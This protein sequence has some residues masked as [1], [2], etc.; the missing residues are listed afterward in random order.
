MS[1]RARFV[2]YLAAVHVLMAILAWQVVAMNRLWLIAAELVL[3]GSF[4]LGL[5]LVRGFFA[6]L[7]FVHDSAQLLEDSDL[8]SRVRDVGQPEIDRLI[9]VYNRMVDSLREERVRLQEQHHFLT[10]VLHESP[11]GIL[12]LDLEG[13]ITLM[14]PAAERLL[15]LPGGRATET[16]PAALDHPLA[17]E[18]ARVPAGESRVVALWGGRRVRIVHGTFPDRGFRRS[19]YLLE[20]LTEELR[21]S[22]KAAYER[23]IRM[24]SHEVNNTVGAS[25]SL[26]HSCLEYGEQLRP[27]DRRDY[28]NALRVVIA[29]TEQLTLFMRSFADVVRLPPPQRRP[30]DIRELLDGI[31]GLLE[32]E[33]ERRHIALRWEGERSL[34]PLPLD[35]VQMEQALLNILK[36]AVEAAGR[37]G[38]VTIR[39]RRENCRAVLEIEDSG[40]GIPPEARDQLF[41]PFFSTKEHGQGIGLTMVQE[42]LSNHDCTFS[43]DSRPGHPTRFT[44]VFAGSGTERA[45][46]P[47]PPGSTW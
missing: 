2:A 16:A 28:E 20:E 27:D 19:F 11:G 38:T 30:V 14:N 41:T 35:R 4:L 32:A 1:R 46:V 42:V 18:L 22:E 7:D 24:L 43:L 5:H 40:P 23:L 39:Q 34:G 25:N 15:Q 21:Q 10:R 26:L 8:M 17:R 3:V 37:A 36:N 31:T 47:V 13:R 33:L 9:H 6:S 12:V 29:R 45:G 44:I